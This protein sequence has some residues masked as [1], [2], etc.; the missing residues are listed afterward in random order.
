MKHREDF[1]G[2][3]RELTIVDCHSHT[4]TPQRYYAEGPYDLFSL[5]SYFDRDLAGLTDMAAL[6]ACKSDEEKWAM[7]KAALDK[8]RNVSFWRHNILTYQRYFGLQEDELT[9]DNWRAVNEAIRTKTADPDWYDYVS[10]RAVK[11]RTQ[12]RNIPWFDDWAIRDLVTATDETIRNAKWVTEW[13]SLYF[14]PTLRMEYA[15][16]LW[17]IPMVEQVSAFTQTPV[18]DLP[19]LK[20]AL[21]RLV[22][23][24]VELGIIGLKSCHAYFRTL[25]FAP[26][27]ETAVNT[28]FLRALKGEVLT[29]GERRQFEDCMVKW[30]LDFCREKGLL[31]QIH[32]GIQHCFA[33]VTHANPLHLIP[34]LQEYRDVPFDIFHAGMP[35]IHE[36]G[37]L[38][39][40]FPN[41]YANFA[42]TYVI[43]PAMARTALA[44]CIDLVPGS[45]ILAFGSDI[46]FPE[47]IG[48]HLDM[49]FS[50]VAD[51]LEQKVKHDFL[52]EREAAALVDKMFCDNGCQLYRL[53]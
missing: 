11:V 51:V 23:K 13:D 26:V 4:T 35:Y 49:A 15:L 33:D 28:I 27:D 25:E 17:R 53:P 29:H 40:L 47:L 45:R 24:Y 52:S 22:D 32:T 46:K 34:L 21:S 7:Y 39:K 36:F 31:F 44:E 48:S 6:A 41:A 9:D 30:M 19:S 2:R 12:I 3:M 14:T 42:W 8:G 50:C 37:I 43:S 10:R 1:I 5:T 20:L 16:Y 18:S 38:C